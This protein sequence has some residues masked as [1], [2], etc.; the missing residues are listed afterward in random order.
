MSYRRSIPVVSALSLEESL[1]YWTSV[2]GFHQCFSYGDPPV[3]AGVERDGV[4]IYLTHDPNLVTSMKE[5][6]SHPE[7]FLWVSDVRH[8][9]E[10][11]R[12]R[13]ATVV[14]ALTDRPWGARQYVLEDPNGYF[15]KV[16]EPIVPED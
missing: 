9:Y 8:S 7:V 16:A 4:E 3:Y 2:M 1:R 12:A 15:I 10:E 13:G 14:E 11:H 6:G 5:A